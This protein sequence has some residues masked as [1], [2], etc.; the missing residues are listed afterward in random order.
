MPKK[1]KKL[2]KR[3]SRPSTAESDHILSQISW[4]ESE[5]IRINPDFGGYAKECFLACTR[6]LQLA[7]VG[8]YSAG[9]S[10]FL[11]A[12]LGEQIL[13]SGVLPTTGAPIYIRQGE[14]ASFTMKFYNG[15]HTQ[16][17]IERLHDMSSRAE[18]GGLH[19]DFSA[20]ELIELY[21]P[22][23]LLREVF[24]VDTP[25]LNAPNE[26]DAQLTERILETSD[27]I[28]WL[29]SAEQVLNNTEQQ[30]LKRFSERY[31]D[32]ALC[33]ISKIDLVDRGDRQEVLTYAR[34]QMKGYFK[35]IVSASAQLALRGDASALQDVLSALKEEVLP[36]ARTWV[37]ENQL[38][39]MTA[40][41]K[42]LKKFLVEEHEETKRYLKAIEEAQAQHQRNLTT[43]HREL[44]LEYQQLSSHLKD[45]YHTFTSTLWSSLD[46]YTSVEPYQEVVEGFF[47]DDYVISYRDVE[48]WKVSDR[49]LEHADE[50]VETFTQKGLDHLSQ[51]LDVI[52]EKLEENLQRLLNSVIEAHTEAC[53][54]LLDPVEFSNYV[55]LDVHNKYEIDDA[56]SMF[57]HYGQ[58]ALSCGGTYS[59]NFHIASQELTTKPNLHQVRELADIY[60]PVSVFLGDCETRADTVTEIVT[61][62][63][64]H[65]F[66]MMINFTK[67]DLEAS[68]VTIAQLKSILTRV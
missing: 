7:V 63:T 19:E 60:L 40:Y 4:I 22:S 46:T 62:R 23:P 27:A 37:K 2:V 65:F 61:N 17:N 5:L 3:S 12:L 39:E 32:K 53:E 67:E 41:V 15:Q 64:A 24:F 13:P 18:S 56:L 10:T 6:P 28:I 52:R 34:T 20:V 51:R 38:R 58:G 43:F 55:H 29:T 11:N 57:R 42:E 50:K 66:S 8:E 14:S 26:E 54:R 68:Q 36:Q 9:K 59:L 31:Q 48:Y 35:K 21:H 44:L 16:Y 25:G 47:V 33:V 49:F 30:T 45:T 1:S